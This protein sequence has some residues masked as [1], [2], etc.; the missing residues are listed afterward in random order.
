MLVRLRCAERRSWNREEGRGDGK[1]YSNTALDIARDLVRS[2][3]T[4]LQQPPPGFVVGRVV[5]V[6]GVEFV[7]G[8]DGAGAVVDVPG[9]LASVEGAEVGEVVEQDVC[10]GGG[11]CVW[12]KGGGGGGDGGDV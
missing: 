3:A 4:R 6:V 12:D 10:G 5:A 11:C 2:E 8:G 9:G 1:A 7:A